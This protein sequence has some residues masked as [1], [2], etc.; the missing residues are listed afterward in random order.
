MAGHPTLRAE[1]DAQR[2]LIDEQH[3]EIQ[4]QRR[5]IELQFR[6]A[7]DMQ[8]EI[9]DL[10]GMMRRGLPTIPEPTSTGPRDGGASWPHQSAG[11]HPTTPETAP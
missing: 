5:Q 9:D 3:I 7:A 10:K 1:L 2:R 11:F 6:R 4:R 8:A